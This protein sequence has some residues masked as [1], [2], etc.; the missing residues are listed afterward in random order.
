MTPNAS[1]ITLDQIR[2]GLQRPSPPPEENDLHMISL[3][4]GTKVTEAAVLVPLV[5]RD[6][7]VQVLLTQRT[8]HLRDHA[9][10][11]SFPGGRVEPDDPDRESTALRETEE[12][13]GLARGESVVVPVTLGEIAR[14]ADLHE[15]DVERVIARLAQVRLLTALPDGGYAVPATARLREFLD[16]I[17][18]VNG[19]Q[20]R[21]RAPSQMPLPVH[22][23]EAPRGGR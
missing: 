6:G 18:A 3:R 12:E 1:I 5:N 7:G 14:A 2:A 13:I 21:A 8:A 20:T 23:T 4:E 19:P 22:G 9:G 17:D 11:I 16:Y 10:Q 15:R